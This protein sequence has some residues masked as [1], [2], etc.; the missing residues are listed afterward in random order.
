M[1][2]RASVGVLQECI[3]LQRK[4]GQ[5]YNGQ[6]TSVQQAHYYPSGVKTIHEIMHAKMLRAK[7]VMEQMEQGGKQ[8]FES[9]EDTYKDLINYASFAVAYLRGQV[10]GQDPNRDSFNRPTHRR[11]HEYEERPWSG[12][13]L[14]PEELK[15]RGL[16]LSSDSADGAHDDEYLKQSAV[17]AAVR[18]LQKFLHETPD[19]D[20]A[21]RTIDQINRVIQA[22]HPTIHTNRFEP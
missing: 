21:Q 19:V 1:E 18:A 12:M 14:Q 6:T 8:N 5:D 10:P 9:L 7:S 4:K 11:E 17:P 22:N 20:E 13:P 3:D 16:P 15:A 2:D